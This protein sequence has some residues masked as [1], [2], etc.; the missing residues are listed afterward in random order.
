M[1]AIARLKQDLRD[2]LKASG[3]LERVT[4]ERIFPTLPTAVQAYE[5]SRGLGPPP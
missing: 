5:A 1:F 3:L 2:E 4:E